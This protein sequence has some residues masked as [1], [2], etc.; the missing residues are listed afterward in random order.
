MITL[1]YG[2]PGGGKTYTAISEILI[3]QLRL[4]R[5]VITN[6]PI[7][8]DN[9]KQLFED[10][11][12][13]RDLLETRVDNDGNPYHAFTGVDDFKDDWKHETE[14]FGPYYL[15]DE[16]H[17]L[18]NKNNKQQHLKTIDEFFALH[19]Q[20]G[21]EICLIT[22]TPRVMPRE[23]LD[24]IELIVEV[25]NLG[26]QGYGAN[27]YVR[28]EKLDLSRRKDS[29]IDETIKKYKPKFFDYYDSYFLI[30]NKSSVK[31]IKNTTHSKSV[32]L[33]PFFLL[34]Y[35]VV[36]VMFLLFLTG[37]LNFDFFGATNKIMESD[38]KVTVSK[39][40]IFNSDSNLKPV[41]NSNKKNK[42][43]AVDEVMKSNNKFFLDKYDL[44][45][46]GYLGKYP[47]GNYLFKVFDD[48]NEMFVIYDYDLKKMGYKI[49]SLTDLAVKVTRGEDSVVL[50]FDN[51]AVKETNKK[52]LFSMGS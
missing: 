37:F 27:S 16:C 18:L 46:F 2:R 15:I 50:L 24:K 49:R 29:L 40:K 12:F 9:K 51:P 39:P 38:N 1:I 26:K 42:D 7:S 19:R 23:I 44:K 28:F 47:G 45:Y 25:A 11:D 30:K 4:G 36:F 10:Y 33:K 14:G 3:P 17:I 32:F 20:Y 13:D 52:S 21:V 5:K 34:T 6:I 22:Q 43:S 41:L 8:D 31:Q 48:S 35:F